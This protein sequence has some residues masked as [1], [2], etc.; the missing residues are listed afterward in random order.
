MLLA[1]VNMPQ[2][3][4]KNVYVKLVILKERDSYVLI[5]GYFTN[6]KMK[7]GYLHLCQSANVSNIDIAYLAVETKMFGTIHFNRFGDFPD[8]TNA[9]NK[10]VIDYVNKYKHPEDVAD[11]QIRGFKLGPLIKTKYD[12]II[13]YSG[14]I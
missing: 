9:T 11:N 10:I 3:K 5:F 1:T 13:A 2:Q 4:P 14:K 8:L 7:T 6:Y 12:N